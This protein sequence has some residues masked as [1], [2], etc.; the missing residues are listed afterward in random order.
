MN[1]SSTC[2]APSNEGVQGGVY[3]ISQLARWLNCHPETARQTA[4]QARFPV[5]VLIGRRKY[6][7]VSAIHQFFQSTTN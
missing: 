1:T 4:K 3:S 6:W 5:P 7:P 2:S